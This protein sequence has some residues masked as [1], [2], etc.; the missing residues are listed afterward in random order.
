MIFLLSLHSNNR[1]YVDFKR[2]GEAVDESLSPEE[3]FLLPVIGLPGR[4]FG[5]II[6]NQVILLP[7]IKGR[8]IGPLRSLI[9]E[10]PVL[11]I[12]IKQLVPKLGR[13]LPQKTHGL[14]NLTVFMSA[15][16][17]T[18]IHNYLL[19]YAHIVM[20]LKGKEEL[21]LLFSVTD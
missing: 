16:F 2:K 7:H 4:Q 3:V 14:L 8:H 9:L 11:G 20:D 17:F 15:M 13:I 18:A 5:L 6:V 21:S 19:L 1:C 12:A 10:G